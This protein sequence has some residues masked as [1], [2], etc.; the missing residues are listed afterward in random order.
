MKISRFTD[1]Q[2]MKILKQAESGIAVTDLCR[3]H[4]MNSVAFYK[5]RA[6]MVE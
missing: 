6:R 4:G 2:I 5:W 3:D 1:S